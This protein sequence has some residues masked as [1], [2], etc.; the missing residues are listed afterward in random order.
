LKQTGTQ[1]EKREAY[2]QTEGKAKRQND[3]DWQKDRRM[4]RLIDGQTER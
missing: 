2:R 3:Q 4:K 1:R